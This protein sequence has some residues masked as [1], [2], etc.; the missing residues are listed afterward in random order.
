MEMYKFAVFLLVLNFAL[1]LT[2]ILGLTSTTYSNYLEDKINRSMLTDT[3]EESSGE[4]QS[5]VENAWDTLAYTSGAIGL[6]FELLYHTTMSL[7]DMLANE[8]FDL[9]TEIVNMFIVF[10]VVIYGVGIAGFMRGV[11]I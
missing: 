7:P 10:Q 6:F 2:S 1:G 9:P 4:S 8:P 3:L 11:L 5:F